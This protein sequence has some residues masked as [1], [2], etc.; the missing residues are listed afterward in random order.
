MARTFL[1]IIGRALF[2]A[3]LIIQCLSLVK[4]HVRYQ[5]EGKNDYWFFLVLF[6][7]PGICVWGNVVM[8]ENNS[9]IYRLWHVWLGYMFALTTMVGWI[10]GSFVIRKDKLKSDEFLGPN[11][12]KT[13]LCITPLLM[14]LLL[15]ST[16]GKSEYDKYRESLNELS[17]TVTLDL[18]D[19][20]EMLE[21]LVDE[22]ENS[23]EI[24][25]GI[26]IAILVLVCAFFFLSPLELLQVKSK[27]QGERTFWSKTVPYIRVTFRVV[28][29]ISFGVLRLILW[30]KYGRNAPIFIAKNG[31][32]LLLLVLRL[33]F[34]G[35]DF[36]SSLGTRS[37]RQCQPGGFV[38]SAASVLQVSSLEFQFRYERL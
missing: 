38:N 9:R 18:F 10:F 7:V 22:N 31:I 11:V 2:V 17:F 29:N 36:S 12:L 19:G 33:C 30:F 23:H 6:F 37:Q 8:E 1:F 16:A 25:K 26:T 24:P 32:S 4:Y 28:I 27:E 21:V 34:Y 15:Q 20:I 35:A 3:L 5:G 14:L 13:T